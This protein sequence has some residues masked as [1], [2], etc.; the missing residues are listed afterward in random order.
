VLM[1]SL[2]S[3]MSSDW[4]GETV[5]LESA[6]DVPVLLNSHILRKPELNRL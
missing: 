6:D 4:L 1:M 5:P 2:Y 3:W